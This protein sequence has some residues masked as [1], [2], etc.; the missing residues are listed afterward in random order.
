[1]H[2]SYET[3]IAPAVKARWQASFLEEDETTLKLKKGPDAPFRAKVARELFAEL[4]EDEQEGLRRR[5]K[6]DAQKARNEYMK[7]MKDGPSKTPEARQ[8]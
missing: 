3:E 8:K 7:A 6:E 1:M 4:S 5:A 2:E